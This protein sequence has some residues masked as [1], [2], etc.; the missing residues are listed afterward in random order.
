MRRPTVSGSRRMTSADRPSDAD[1]ASD[2]RQPAPQARNSGA[3]MSL[4]LRD[5]KNTR[6]PA[7]FN[8]CHDPILSIRLKT[9]KV[10]NCFRQRQVACLL[11]SR[12]KLLVPFRF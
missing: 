3:E 11:S 7:L 12:V 8:D 9:I 6:A 4:L 1:I 2:D 10:A 5:G